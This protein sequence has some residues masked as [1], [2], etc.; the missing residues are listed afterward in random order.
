MKEAYETLSTEETLQAL[1]EMVAVV[2]VGT[3]EGDENEM[4]KIILNF[5][6]MLV[7]SMIKVL[8]NKNFAT[9]N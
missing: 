3:T 7:D 5:G 2:I 1:S 9:I 8:D 4:N 6:H